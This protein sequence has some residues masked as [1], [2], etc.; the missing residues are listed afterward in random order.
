MSPNEEIFQLAKS[1]AHGLSKRYPM[2]E[3]DDI[4]QEIALYTITNKLSLPD[5]ELTPQEQKE[6]IYYLK[7]DMRKHGDKF[8]RKEKAAK[9]GYEIE[10][11][12]FYSL[13]RLKD[14]VEVYYQT[15][16]AEHPPIS[17]EDSVKRSGDGSEAGTWMA[18][19][20]D[21]ERGLAMLPEG[22]RRRL[23]DRYKLFAHMNDSDY[24]FS[25]GLTEDQVRGRL[26]TALRALQRTLGGSNPW[27]KGPSPR[28]T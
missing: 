22:H 9:A 24:A 18:S 12:A 14:L 28:T 10:D 15:G 2:V 20:I 8:C 26:R 23:S 19:L 16:V 17:R 25:L 21:V 27:Q 5:V 3:R 6:Q 11:E 1:E 4:F 13:P 7:R